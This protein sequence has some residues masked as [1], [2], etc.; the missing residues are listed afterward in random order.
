MFSKNKLFFFIFCSIFSHALMFCAFFLSWSPLH[1][2]LEDPAKSSILSVFM[3][4]ST[5][6]AANV[7]EA[8][9]QTSA[10]A[11]KQKS[12]LNSLDT[13]DLVG[14]D[15]IPSRSIDTNT[16][17]Q[18]PK[19]SSEK[20]LPINIP[21]SLGPISDPSK[22]EIDTKSLAL[23]DKMPVGPFGSSSPNTRWGNMNSPIGT[24]PGGEQSINVIQAQEI[25]K[26]QRKQVFLDAIKLRH[27]YILNNT[28]ILACLAFINLDATQ[29]S[30]TCAPPEAT[31]QEIALLNGAVSMSATKPPN[32]FCYPFGHHNAPL[33]CP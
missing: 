12:S 10:P 14:V 8:N 15:I 32:A 16:Y 21:E 22:F 25:Q 3:Q 18:T 11:N 31:P 24:F 6:A 26:R 17:I 1:Q 20:P 33:L 4:S 19:T 9:N 29:G 28:E 5:I 30:V 13:V 23:N 2:S 27:S 7:L